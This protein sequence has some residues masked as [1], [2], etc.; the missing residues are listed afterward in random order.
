MSKFLLLLHEEPTAA[1]N[2]SP[3]QMQDLIQ[4]YVDWSARMAQA[5]HLLGG[6]KLV[7]GEGRIVRQDDE[8]LVVDGPFSETKEVIG[9]FFMIE[10][11]D[12]D[13][14][15]Q[16]SRD[17]PHVRYGTRIEIREIDERHQEEE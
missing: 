1:S 5:G 17:C 10:A 8:G 9:G 4:E 13:Q 15:V 12:Y 11:D 16:L 7:E 3:Q 14:A 6:Q 2:Y